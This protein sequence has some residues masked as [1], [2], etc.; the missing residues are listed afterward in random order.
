MVNIVT[1]Q[2]QGP[3]DNVSAED[4]INAILG[5]IQQGSNV[6]SYGEGAAIWGTE[7]FLKLR[8]ELSKG[9]ISQSDFVKIGS[10]IAPELSKTIQAIGG[11]GS[12]A[13]NAVSPY[14][15]Q[16][17]EA[18]RDFDIYKTGQ[19]LL[20]RDL[21]QNELYALRPKFSGPNG[22][23]TGKAYLAELAQQEAK[24]PDALKKKAGA[25]GGQVNDIYRS[26]LGRD[27]TASESDYYGR[28]LASGEVSPYEAEQYLKAGQEYQGI[29]DKEFRGG[30]KDELLGYNQKAFDKA[31]ESILSSYTR[32]G[33]QNS[34]D[35][36]FALANA[37]KDLTAE[38]DK[39]LT[40]LTA[41]QYGGN[42]DAARADY[43]NMLNQYLQGKAYTTSRSDKYLDYLTQRAD[44]GTDYQR[45]M[46]DYMSFLKSQ[47]KAKKP[48]AWGAAAMLG[49]AA[50]GSMA[51][52]AG[53]AAGAQIGGGLYNYLLQ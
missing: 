29:K 30:L 21:T 43:E 39:Y 9:L 38:G 52:P 23:D 28:L 47:P 51:G 17:N 16:F 53:A 5:R 2:N 49:G 37:S 12:K 13:A 34:S 18:N 19:E 32:A 22:A 7:E 15:A 42:K 40:G 25:F 45:Q 1:K 35:L 14:A 27:A 3:T 24:S 33:L 6:G 36:D 50:L 46:D 8:D 48:S 10:A 20:G 44:Q 4:R 11:R 41:S 31:K 26:L